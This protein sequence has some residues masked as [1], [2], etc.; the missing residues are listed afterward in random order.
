MHQLA[1]DKSPRLRAL[2]R[3]GIVTALRNTNLGF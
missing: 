1:A 3:T 2:H